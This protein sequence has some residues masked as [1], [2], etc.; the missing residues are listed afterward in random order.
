MYGAAARWAVVVGTQTK[1]GGAPQSDRLGRVSGAMGCCLPVEHSQCVLW[2][3]GSVK[4][5]L[6][7]GTGVAVRLRQWL[8][9]VSGLGRECKQVGGHL[10]VE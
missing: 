8:R 3:G 1:T 2:D 10:Q 4:D 5:A 7:V 9:R 6:V